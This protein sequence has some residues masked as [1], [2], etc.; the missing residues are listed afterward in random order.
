VADTRTIFFGVRTVAI[1]QSP[2]RVAGKHFIIIVNGRRIFCRG[3]NWV[4]AD[5]IPSRVSRERTEHLVRLALE[6]NY[7]LLR[8]WGGGLYAG[9]DLLDLCDE[10]GLL[11]WHDLLF[12][13]SKYPADDLEFLANVRRE[14]TWAAREFGSHPSMAVWC[15]NNEIELAYQRWGYTEHGRTM[16]CYGLFH[17][18]IP[19]ILK[20]ENPDIPYWPSSPYSP[21]SGDAN[22]PTVGDQ[23]Q[24]DVSLNPANHDFWK[25]RQFVD[26][27]PNEGGVLGA[28]TPATLR[29]AFGNSCT[30]RS[31]VWEHHDNAV[32]FWSSERGQTYRA[33]EFW[34]GCTPET[35]P[36]ND[37]LFASGLLQAEGLAEYIA[38]YRRR[39]FSSAAAI[40]WMFNDSWPATHSWT[41]IDY[42]L[43]KKISFHPV[44]RAF[45]P[46]TVV[47]AEEGDAIAVFGVN[48]TPAAWTGELEAGFF[49]TLG[50]LSDV[51][52]KTV[53]LPANAS[54]VLATL[55]RSS[56][57]RMGAT[58]T[59]AYARLTKDHGLAAQHRLFIERF[60][61]LRLA[62]PA[63]EIRVENRKAFFSSANFAWGVALDLDGE[64]SVADNSFDILPGLRY[65]IDWNDDSKIPVV[66]KVGN[67]LI[68]GT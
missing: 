9:H 50:G 3:G 33:V 48:D 31:M 67:E 8:I 37:Y 21:D 68:P 34:I 5:I 46:V 52:K 51:V 53:V 1:E 58:K 42:Y 24:W 56:M 19:R 38:N 54:T 20:Q 45:L 2:H 27:F 55:P 6:S 44:R 39:M 26:R 63:I 25:Y 17:L 43:R 23:H 14:I 7:N 59:G 41:T 36:L 12:A 30:F 60:K 66:L 65:E 4:P 49:G 40:Y 16:P 11:V 28:S 47:V 18:V 64:S 22:D 15:G 61:A 10:H 62:K 35:M 32:N 29:Q 57:E 13:C